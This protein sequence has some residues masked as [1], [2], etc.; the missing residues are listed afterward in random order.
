MQAYEEADVVIL[1][2][3]LPHVGLQELKRTYPDAADE[4]DDPEFRRQ[5]GI[6]DGTSWPIVLVGY[7]VHSL[8]RNSGEIRSL[9][10]QAKQGDE[11]FPRQEEES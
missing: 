1:S 7:V 5:M 2:D 6:G 11:F 10:Y 3:E 9:P 8:N 4:L